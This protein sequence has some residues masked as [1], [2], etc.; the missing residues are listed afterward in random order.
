MVNP[1]IPLSNLKAALT[2]RLLRNLTVKNNEADYNRQLVM[3]LLGKSGEELIAALNDPKFVEALPS[4]CAGVDKF[5]DYVQNMHELGLI[6]RDR[7]TLLCREEL[8]IQNEV[9]DHE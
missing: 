6:A 2:G 9:S 4:L 7:C 1:Q 8:K 3:A 5:I